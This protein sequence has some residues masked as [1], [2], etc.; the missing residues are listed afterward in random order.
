M[1][2][3]FVLERREYFMAD[4][5]H[6]CG[7]CEVNDCGERTFEKLK[8][9]KGSSIKKIFAIISGK[10]G[11]GKSLF[12][13]LLAVE[14]NRAG[15]K[16]AIID[17]DVTGPSIPQAFGL[18]GQTAYS[19]ETSIYPVLSKTG[20]KIMSANLL[21]QDDEA[22]IVWRGPL[23]AGFVQQLFTDV[24]YGEV[25]YLLIDM[26]PGTSDIPLTVFQLIP[27]DGAL[28]VS[29][30]QELVSMVVAK[31]VNM[32]KMMNINLLGVAMNMAYI[33]CPDCHKK[34]NVF[35]NK[36]KEEIAKH[37]LD[38]LAE[39]P[40]DPNLAKF[41]DKGRIEDYHSPDLEKLVKTILKQ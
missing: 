25:D 23:V 17:A 12:T 9:N 41:V 34:I 26:P 22:P 4:C 38:I 31:S 20:I 40:I 16:V 13:S 11:V 14:L 28:V 36:Y 33:S 8:P 1:Y 39:L 37:D 24:N 18:K 32:A 21:L 7:S 3:Y 29:S 35:G 30:P 10:G 6:E 27:I 5:N 15:K 2:N 19:D